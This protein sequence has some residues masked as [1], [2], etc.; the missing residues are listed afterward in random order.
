MATQRKREAGAPR[1][2]SELVEEGSC[3]D[4]DVGFGLPCDDRR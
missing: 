2:E 1:Y 4:V 3:E